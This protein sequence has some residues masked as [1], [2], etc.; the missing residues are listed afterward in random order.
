VVSQ[1][2]NTPPVVSFMIRT[3]PSARDPL[4]KLAE[5]LMSTIDETKKYTEIRANTAF[6]M[7]DDKSSMII[8]HIF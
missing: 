6:F 7:E 1:P 8:L 2:A 3:T 5:D 4:I